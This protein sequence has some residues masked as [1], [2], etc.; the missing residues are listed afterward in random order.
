MNLFRRVF[1]WLSMAALPALAVCFCVSVRNG[2][3]TRSEWSFLQVTEYKY[4]HADKDRK[5]ILIEDGTCQAL[6]VRP[7]SG[8]GRV[9]ILLNPR[10]KNSLKYMPDL[11]FAIPVADLDSLR[12]ISAMSPEVYGKLLRPGAKADEWE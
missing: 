7:D 6:G 11:G 4:R 9:W 10:S 8:D 3:R 1:L 5:Y 12:K 2:F